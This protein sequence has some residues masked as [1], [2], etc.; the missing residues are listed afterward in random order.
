MLGNS[1]LSKK[2]K[3]FLIGVIRKIRQ[4]CSIITE[5]ERPNKISV[6][7]SLYKNNEKWIQA[8]IINHSYMGMYIYLFDFIYIKE[9]D[10]QIFDQSKF[11]Q[12]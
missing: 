11:L 1:I 7:T 2:L 10:V 9:I 8:L 12:F 6:F 3:I 5:G 4:F